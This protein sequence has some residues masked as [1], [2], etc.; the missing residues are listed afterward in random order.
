MATAPQVD[1]ASFEV[2][3]IETKDPELMAEL[4]AK[5]ARNP[6]MRILIS[7]GGW[8]FSR[9]TGVFEGQQR[10][11][12]ASCCQTITAAARRFLIASL[13]VVQVE[14]AGWCKV[15]AGSFRHG[16]TNSSSLWPGK[17]VAGSGSASIFPRL[18]STAANRAKFISSAISYALKY[19]FDGIDIDW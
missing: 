18:A 5:R 19:D 10:T 1:G 15:E 8:S 11:C 6:G 3:G 2:I 16:H 13:W 4:K 17:L 12:T 7:I 9:A 14:L